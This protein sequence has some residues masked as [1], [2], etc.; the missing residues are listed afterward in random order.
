MIPILNELDGIAKGIF[1]VIDRIIPDPA[2][3]AQAKEKVLEMQQNGELHVLDKEVE[4]RIS[5]RQ[6]ESAMPDDHTTRNLAYLITAGFF[7]FLY[8]VIFSSSPMSQTESI[9][10][11][12]LAGAFTSV[13]SY[14]FGTSLGSKIKDVFMT[15]SRIQDANSKNK[16]VK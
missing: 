10:T 13:I 8:F 7:I 14:Y 16:L 11:G 9:L 4:D 15:N 6:R 2:Q 3:A 12:V 1:G 5:A